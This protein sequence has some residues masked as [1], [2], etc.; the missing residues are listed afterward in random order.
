MA[1]VTTVGFASD[2]IPDQNIQLWISH[3][4][5]LDFSYSHK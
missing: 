5:H 3:F 1:D 2:F 4:E